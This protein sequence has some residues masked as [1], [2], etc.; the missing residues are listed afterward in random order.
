MPTPQQ[1]TVITQIS[2][3]QFARGSR[4]FWIANNEVDGLMA[5]APS[6]IKCVALM[7][8]ALPHLEAEVNLQGE[9]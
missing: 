6:I 8:K 1:P 3:T 7:A 2:F 9:N 5:Q 4:T